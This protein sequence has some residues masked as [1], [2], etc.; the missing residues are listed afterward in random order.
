MDL[1]SR[2]PPIGLEPNASLTAQSSP[3][4]NN[5]EPLDDIPGDE[6]MGDLAMGLSSSF[7]HQAIKNSKGKSFWDTFSESSSMGGART[8][9]PPPSFLPRG[10]S[11]GMSE[12]AGMVS[13][14]LAGQPGFPVRP[15]R[16]DYDTDHVKLTRHRLLS[17]VDHSHPPLRRSHVA[18]TTSAVE[19]TTLTRRAS[20]GEQSVPA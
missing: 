18:L 10:S 4:L 8:P 2:F 9:P 5:Q 17:L 13:P 11:S 20:S 6:I 19:T 1:E 12:D 15:P 7:K 16:Q 14:S 3:N